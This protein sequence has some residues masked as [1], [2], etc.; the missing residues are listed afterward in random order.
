MQNL[1]DRLRA[2]F[3]KKYIGELLQ[4][5]EAAALEIGTWKFTTT[6]PPAGWQN[7]TFDDTDAVGTTRTVTI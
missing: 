4:V 1:I 7:I 5:R 2:D 3:G 6:T